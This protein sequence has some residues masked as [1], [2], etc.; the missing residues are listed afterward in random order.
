[1]QRLVNT[2][3]YLLGIFTGLFI[4]VWSALFLSRYMPLGFAMLISIFVVGGCLAGLG[5]LR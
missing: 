3:G 4:L 5:R 1:M 2:I